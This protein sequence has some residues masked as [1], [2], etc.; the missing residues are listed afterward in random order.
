MNPLSNQQCRK[1]HLHVAHCLFS[2]GAFSHTSSTPKFILPTL[3][4]RLRHISALL[5][6]EPSPLNGRSFFLPCSNINTLHFLG[7]FCCAG[8]GGAATRLHCEGSGNHQ[9]MSLSSCHFPP[10]PRAAQQCSLPGPSHRAWV[11][12]SELVPPQN[13]Y[14]ILFPTHTQFHQE[15]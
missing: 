4:D 8:L 2:S 11:L 12:M 14:S 9:R 6:A 1:L 3:I 13:A 5:V 10:I 15:S 7:H